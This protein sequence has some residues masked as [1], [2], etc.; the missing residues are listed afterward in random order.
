MR[1][2]LS[3]LALV[4]WIPAA[5]AASPPPVDPAIAAIVAKVSAERLE[6]DDSRLV[7][8][9]TRNTFSEKLGEERGVFAARA[10]NADQFP[11]I[12]KASRGG[13]AVAYDSSVPNAC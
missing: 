11:D 9:G 4:S 1:K 7:A 2:L 8:V 10:W 5:R 6:A 13:M 3:A 12:A